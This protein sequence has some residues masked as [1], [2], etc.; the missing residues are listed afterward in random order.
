MEFKIHKRRNPKEPKIKTSFADTPIEN[1][2]V[3]L[4]KA[5]KDEPRRRKN[6]DGKWEPIPGVFDWWINEYSVI[7]T[8]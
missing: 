1:G 5:W 4:I 7:N 2:D 3:I 6:A 8:L